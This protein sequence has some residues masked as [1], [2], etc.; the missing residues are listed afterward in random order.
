MKRAQGSLEYLLILAAILAIGVVVVLVA[1][2]LLGAP[3]AQT[4]LQESRYA[5]AIAGVELI[6]YNAAYEGAETIG[7]TGPSAIT[8]TDSQGVQQRLQYNNGLFVEEDP[9]A[10]GDLACTINSHTLYVNR[11]NLAAYLSGGSQLS[12]TDD[13][14]LS[15]AQIT[16]VT[17]GAVDGTQITR[18]QKDDINDV[19]ASKIGPFDA[20]DLEEFV[21][22][23]GVL[24]EEETGIDIEE[25]VAPLGAP[26]SPGQCNKCFMLQGGV[27]YYSLYNSG[28]Y[29]CDTTIV[30]S[31]NDI[32]SLGDM[33][34]TGSNCYQKATGCNLDYCTDGPCDKDGK[35]EAQEESMWCPE[36]CCGETYNK[37]QYMCNLNSPPKY[38]VCL[39]SDNDGKLDH[40]PTLSC[41]PGQE[42]TIN[43]C[44]PKGCLDCFNNQ[45]GV[46]YQSLYSTGKYNCDTSITSSCN[47]I[48][49]LGD[50]AG[51]GS[52]CYQK[53]GG[54]FLDYC[55]DGPCDKDGYCDSEEEW[56]W[57]PEDCCGETYNKGQ[58]FCSLNK[59]GEYNQC[60]DANKDGKL[61]W[62]PTGTCL[63]SKC[64]IYG[65][66]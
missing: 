66:R 20:G 49:S 50:M 58:Y 57:C 39:D 29:N 37:G 2:S 56:M 65:C 19:I 14:R 6:G 22:E 60:Q 18:A 42:C 17:G 10:Y 21:D 11:D 12:L 16:V 63:G 47:D 7:E 27:I 4:G 62:G 59:P 13:G 35:C 64:S 24:D 54:C 52:N 3:A 26:A 61:E 48:C 25:D 9:M 8:F 34:G 33:A 53:A 55:T 1:N 43:G 40:G 32:C 23:D 44:R 51:T 38:N 36:D 15:P 31:C 45:G 28:E 30:S 5:C 41:G 46:M